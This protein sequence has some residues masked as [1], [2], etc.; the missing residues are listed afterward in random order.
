MEL[1]INGN[2]IRYEIQYN[3]KRKKF[4]I[5]IDPSGLVTVKSPKNVPIE[6]IE[7]LIAENI[8]WVEGKHGEIEQR[9]EALNLTGELGVSKYLYIGK[10][11]SAEELIEVGGL[12]QDELKMSLKKFYVSSAKSIIGERLKQYQREMGVK[13]K[14]MKIMDSKAKWGTCSSDKELTFN[15]RLVMAPLKVIDYVVVHELCHLDH[16]NHDRSFWRKVGSIMPDYKEQQEF[17]SKYGQ[18]MSLER[19]G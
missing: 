5:S 17:L 18:F 8:S 2:T 13:F 1:N 10:P 7:K 9:K 15:Y 3:A 6:A 14:S 19:W 16:M 4:A 12:G 11:H